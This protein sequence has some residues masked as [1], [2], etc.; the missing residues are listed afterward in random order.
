V[1]MVMYAVADIWRREMN[2]IFTVVR[3]VTGTIALALLRNK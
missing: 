1:L 2:S 3:I